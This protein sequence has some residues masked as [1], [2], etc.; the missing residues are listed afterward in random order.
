K[1]VNSEWY[2]QQYPD[3]AASN[4]TAEQHYRLF[5]KAEGRKP[6]PPTKFD[7]LLEKAGIARHAFQLLA[8]KNG[9]FNTFKIIACCLRKDGFLGVKCLLMNTYNA[10]MANNKVDYDDWISRNELTISDF[11][12][13]ETKLK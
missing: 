12:V 9:T 13:A 7:L 11:S 10:H 8:K 1:K 2:L 3:V 4:M 5:G 6:G